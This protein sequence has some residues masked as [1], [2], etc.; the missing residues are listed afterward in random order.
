MQASLLQFLR[1]YQD[2]AE[3]MPVVIWQESTAQHHVG[4]KV[5]PAALHSQ[6]AHSRLTPLGPLPI[7][8]WPHQHYPGQLLKLRTNP[9][10]F[11]GATATGSA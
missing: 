3:R 11:R 2:N 9:T 1:V 5:R 8:S 7:S 10:P 4:F 6:F